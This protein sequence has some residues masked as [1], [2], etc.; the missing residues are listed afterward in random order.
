MSSRRIFKT[1]EG[2]LSK[3]YIERD[4]LFY[5]AFT[6]SG[7]QF[8]DMAFDLPFLRMCPMHLVK[9]EYRLN[10][11]GYTSV[12][13]FTQPVDYIPLSTIYF[14][15]NQYRFDFDNEHNLHKPSDYTFY[16]PFK[17]KQDTS[18][19][20]VLTASIRMD[21]HIPHSFINKYIDGAYVLNGG[22]CHDES[23]FNTEMFKEIRSEDEVGFGQ[24]AIKAQTV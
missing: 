5:Y 9:M 10:F 7:R 20:Y 6:V 21:N 16:Y 11:N 14:I 18:I 2:M 15:R 1:W 13:C 4:G 23:Y 22:F 3:D 19:P 8:N 24:L 12:E 17:E